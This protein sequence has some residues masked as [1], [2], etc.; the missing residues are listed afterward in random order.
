MPKFD[1]TTFGEGGLRL[2]VPKG[3]RIE[4]TSQFEVNIAGAE[5]NVAGN[6]SSLGWNCGWLSSLPDTPLGR[7]VVNEYRRLGIDLSSVVWEKQGRVSVYYVEYAEPPI[8]I[9]VYYDRADSCLT[10]LT[11]DKVNWDYLFDTKLLH[12]TGI[13]VPLSSACRQI[14]FDAMVQ[15]RDQGITTVFDINYRQLLWNVD[16]ARSQLLEIL[17][18]VD[19]LVC[20]F[21][22]AIDVFGCHGEPEEVIE[23]LR[24]LTPAGHIVVSLSESGLIGWDGVDTH[25]VS[26]K[27]VNIIDR[28]GAGDAMVAGVLHGWLQGDFK[29]GLHYGVELASLVMSQ[30]GEVAITTKHEIEEMLSTDFKDIVR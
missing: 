17:P 2:S 9:K 5:A 29:K 8:P 11:Q 19:I 14:V 21:R 15:A 6:L 28:V 1:L 30:Y 25:R 13:T 24:K 12:M 20:S 22:D 27:L 26:A 18:Y 16:T 23:Q 7:R 4:T 10:K 3:R